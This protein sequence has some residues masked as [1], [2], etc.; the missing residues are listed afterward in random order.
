MKKRM[1]HSD[2]VS[3]TPYLVR[4][5]VLLMAT[6]FGLW[7]RESLDNLIKP[8]YKFKKGLPKVILGYFVV[9]AIHPI[10]ADIAFFK[11]TFPLHIMILSFCYL[12][13]GKIIAVEIPKHIIEYLKSKLK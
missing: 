8:N 5:A 4:S 3:F 11:K 10:L 9:L 13:L 2:I 1:N 6:L 12:D 7:A